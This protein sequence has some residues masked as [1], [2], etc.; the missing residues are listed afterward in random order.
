M[1]TD[2][3]DKA[4]AAST[5]APRIEVT[6]NDSGSLIT[7]SGRWTSHSVNQV[8]ARMREIER[9]KSVSHVTIDMSAILGLDTA[10][11][12]L[13]ERLRQSLQTRNIEVSLQGMRQTWKPLM[14]EVA[15]AVERVKNVVR[16]KRDFFLIRLFETIGRGVFSAFNDFKMAMHILGST[17]RGSQMKRGRGS[18]ISMPAIVHQMDMMGV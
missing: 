18:G 11:A 8:D 4:R 16:P 14:E 6:G 15:K 2:A 12:W 3:T 5:V 7:L 10:G 9:S 1:L 13:I 17:I